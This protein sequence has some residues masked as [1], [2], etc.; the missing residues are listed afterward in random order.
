MPPPYP[1]ATTHQELDAVAAD[2]AALDGEQDRS[3]LN[4]MLAMQRANLP[5]AAD[6]NARIRE[7]AGR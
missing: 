2:I 3:D 7:A 1:Q 6:M 5:P 4:G